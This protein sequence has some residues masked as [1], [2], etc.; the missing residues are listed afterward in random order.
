MLTRLVLALALPLGAAT[1]LAA[2]GFDATGTGP[3]AG[4]ALGMDAERADDASGGDAAVLFEAGDDDD[5]RADAPTPPDVAV[6]D[7]FTPPDNAAADAA[8]AAESAVDAGPAFCDPADT[9]LVACYRFDGD[10]KDGSAF[11]NDLTATGVSYVAGVSGKALS[12]SS[13]AKVTAPDTAS[14]AVTNA[15]TIELW[16]RARTLPSTGRVGLIDDDGRF[17]L[18]VYAPGVPRATSPAPLDA[19]AA[20][21]VGTWTHVA[22]TY[23]GATMTLYVNGTA[24]VKQ[25][26][27][28]KFGTPSGNGVAVGM[29]SPNGDIL[30]GEL[31]SLRVFRVARSATQICKAAGSC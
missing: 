4:L 17:G 29:N 10:T 31:D 28:G 2:C 26:I 11:K 19:P 13:T 30:D 20:L 18:F 14:L 25:T 24:V 16:V 7:T 9:T 27:A 22:Y 6:A 21:V 8:D 1:T 12:L 3:A 23:D 5:A 15:M